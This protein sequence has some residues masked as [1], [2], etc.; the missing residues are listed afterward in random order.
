MTFKDYQPLAN[1]TLPELGNVV[2]DLSHMVLGMVSE[3]N[4][5]DEAIAKK[6]KV[7]IAEEL[8]DIEWYQAGYLKIR[9][10]DMLLYDLLFSDAKNT[11]FE[12]TEQAL[13]FLY[14]VTSK[15]SDLVKKNMA[16]GKEI[17]ESR[18]AL[19]NI[20]IQGCI[21][22]ICKFEEIDLPLALRNNID[23][24]KARYGDKFT[25]EKAINRNTE[26]ERAILEKS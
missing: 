20:S 9:G 6:D 16:Y 8:A 4:E 18:E 7:N 14:K 2:L 24:L 1:K 12:S 19:Y 11:S 17:D 25:T 26:V 15:L 22:A 23:K 3:L 5:L 10:K 13:N 21:F